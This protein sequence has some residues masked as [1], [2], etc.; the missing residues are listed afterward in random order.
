V[1]N[2]E[3]HWDEAVELV[4]EGRCRVWLLY[5]SG[6]INGFDDASLQIHQTLGVSIHAD[7]RSDMP[8]TRA[9]WS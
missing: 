2:L 5:M 9:G 7:G 4:G 3:Q 6:S 1:T 8:R